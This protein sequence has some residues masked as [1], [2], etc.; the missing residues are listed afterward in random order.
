MREFEQVHL[1]REDYLI[2]RNDVSKAEQRGGAEGFDW[3]KEVETYR[4]V[5]KL[6]EKIIVK[7]VTD[8]KIVE[9]LVDWHLYH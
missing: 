2:R 8:S 6:G 7:R 9:D 1:F 5:S 3:Q 4:I